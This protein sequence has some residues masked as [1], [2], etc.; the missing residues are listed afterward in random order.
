VTA[1][2]RIAGV[3]ASTGLL[4]V[5][6]LILVAL[7]QPAVRITGSTPTDTMVLDASPI[8]KATPAIAGSGQVQTPVPSCMDGT[9]Y[10]ATFD[11]VDETIEGESS[12]AEAVGLV[13]LTSI[14]E[15]KLNP[16]RQDGPALPSQFN[17]VFR[18]ATFEILQV[19][20]GDSQRLLAVRVFGGRYGC[21][22][23]EIAGYPEFVVGRE[24][25]VFAQKLAG[26]DG[27]PVAELTAPSI[28]PVNVGGL[29]ETPV[30]G[31]MT[32]TEALSRV[33]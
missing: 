19:A 28:W 18:L 22:S 12:A 8:T 15:G 9:R 17:R 10:V 29:V 30:D 11:R 32:P 31:L 2:A 6:V 23:W 1:A 5:A 4:L 26:P 3:L 25:L 7:R 16:T 14:S 13:R 27:K 21:D 24:Y 20:K 33:P